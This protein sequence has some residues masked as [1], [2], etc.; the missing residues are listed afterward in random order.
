MDFIK[1][2]LSRKFL[3]TIGGVAILALTASGIEDEMAQA[4]VGAAIALILAIYTIS[5]AGVDKEIAKANG[6]G[7]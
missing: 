1:K 3:S 6:N 5:Q 2:Y 4:V 7:G